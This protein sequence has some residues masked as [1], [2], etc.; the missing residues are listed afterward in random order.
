MSMEPSKSAV[1]Q[2]AADSQRRQ[3]PFGLRNEEVS[4]LR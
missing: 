3:D 4:G 2:S 1:S